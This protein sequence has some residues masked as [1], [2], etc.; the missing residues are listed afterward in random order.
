MSAFGSKADI[1]VSLSIAYAPAFTEGCA[2]ASIGSAIGRQYRHS[3]IGWAASSIRP[4][5][6]G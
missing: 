3:D 2:L 1:S 5:I 4:D 6:G